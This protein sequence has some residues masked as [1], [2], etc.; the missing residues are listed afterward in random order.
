SPHLDF[1]T[2]SIGDDLLGQFF[3]SAWHGMPSFGFDT[4]RF[5]LWEWCRY[6]GSRSIACRESAMDSS[7]AFRHVGK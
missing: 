6:K 5:S 3:L 7:A 2:R 4:T 1:D